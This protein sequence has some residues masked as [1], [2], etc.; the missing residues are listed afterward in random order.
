M[1]LFL[2]YDH[3]DYILVIVAVFVSAIVVLTKL[4]SLHER[5][6]GNVIHRRLLNQPLTKFREMY[7]GAWKDIFVCYPPP[8]KAFLVGQPVPRRSEEI[9][10]GINRSYFLCCFRTDNSVSAGHRPKKPSFV[11]FSR[12]NIGTK[13]IDHTHGSGEFSHAPRIIQPWTNFPATFCLT[14]CVLIGRRTNKALWTDT[15]A[16]RLIKLDS[17]SARSCA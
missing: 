1:P 3:I 4:E 7:L 13:E 2:G 5:T 10:R 8:Q 9:V 15:K 6:V 16:S 11:W 12:N 14:C 17:I